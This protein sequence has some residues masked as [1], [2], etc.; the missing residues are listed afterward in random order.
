VGKFFGLA[1]G[2]LPAFAI[3]DQ[4]G[5][6]KYLARNVKAGAVKKYVK[7][8]LV[9]ARPAPAR[10]PP[11]FRARP[12]SAARDEAGAA[13][14]LEVGRTP[15]TWAQTRPSRTA[16]TARSRRRGRGPAQRTVPWSGCRIG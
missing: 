16:R 8:F 2:D 12:G 15:A 11:R 10:P 9:R 13:G 5:D 3:H 7:D 1:D 4:A 6:G 14:H